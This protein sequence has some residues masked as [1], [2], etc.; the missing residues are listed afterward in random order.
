MKVSKAALQRRS[1][2]GGQEMYER[3]SVGAETPSAD[4]ILAGV[5]GTGVPMLVSEGEGARQAGGRHGEDP[6]GEGHRLL[7]CQ[8]PT[9]GAPRKDKGSGAVSTCIDC[10]RAEGGVS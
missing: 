7:H 1:A 3:V 10:A 9:T 8:Y 6:Q 2:R 4:R 5:D